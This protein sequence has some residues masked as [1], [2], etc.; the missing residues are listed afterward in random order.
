MLALF[1]FQCRFDVG[2][3]MWD[4]FPRFLIACPPGAHPVPTR[5][6]PAVC[7]SAPVFRIGT[8][9]STQLVF[10]DSYYHT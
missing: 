5:L 6:L 3:V 8:Q 2:F 9:Y 10:V 4:A 7:T 1:L